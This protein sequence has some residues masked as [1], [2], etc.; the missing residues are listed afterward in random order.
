[1]ATFQ[2]DIVSAERHV[3][4]DQVDLLV[5]PGVEGEV[6]ILPSHAPLLTVLKPGEI[7][8]VKDG[9]NNFIAVSGGFMEV[10]PEKVTIL[11]DTAERLD[12]IDIERA[13]AALKA[14]QERIASAPVD[15]DL[16]RALASL[17]RSQA[18]IKVA[19]R[20]RNRPL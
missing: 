10:M 19:R 5:A 4:S 15:M 9:E 17:R 1:M 7:R 14:A 3:S 6:A 13:E 2:L 20:R 16:H 12:E 11:A 18:R 8:V